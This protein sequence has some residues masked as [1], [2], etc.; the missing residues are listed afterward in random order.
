MNEFASDE[1]ES[2]L[3]AI[4]SGE[5]QGEDFDASSWFWLI[6]L[7]VVVPAGLLLIGWWL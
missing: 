7:G 3:A 4:D 6:A 5:Q 1:L 2:R